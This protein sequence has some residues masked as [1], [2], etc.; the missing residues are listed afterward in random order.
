MAMETTSRY[1][2][3]L[4]AV[5]KPFKKLS[6]I[7]FL[8]PDNSIAFSLDNNYKRGYRTKY[9]TRAFIQSGTL[10]VSL[11]NGERRKATITLSNLDRAFDYAVNKI[12]FGQKI[13]LSMGLVLPDGTDFYL[14]QGVFYIKDPRNTFQPDVKQAT[15]P[16]VDKWNYLN[17]TLFGNLENSYQVDR[18]TNIFE[19]MAS[20]LKLSKYDY[21]NNADILAQ[22]DNVTPVFTNYYNDKIYS[23][24]NGDGSTTENIAMTAVPYTLTESGNSNFSKVILGLN[25]MLAGIIGY[26]QTGA[27]RV[28]PS[29]DDIDDR[30][31][32]IYWAFTPENSVLLGLT[33]NIKNS[34]VKNDII[35]V[36]E[37][38]TG[39]EV[40]G[41]AT[42]YD[43]ASDTNVNLI[44]KKTLRIENGNYW[45]SEQCVALAEWQLKR[46]TVLQKSVSI[47]STQLFHL[48]ENGLVSVKRTD[49]EGSP[50]ERHIVQSFS[51]PIG[52][53]GNMTINAT[54]VN[55][56]PQI[57]VTS[58]SEV[59]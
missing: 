24:A 26:D 58:S 59:S 35:V 48:V 56:F 43:P 22:I 29:Q 10:N 52:E 41:R 20:I 49:K 25:D 9:D 16:L 34:D 53:T 12:W 33:E 37:G 38:L 1:I 14:P 27:L 28:E 5:S 4:N 32:P 19:A 54:S 57:T 2:Q 8:Q 45:N 31:K 7:E 11:Q 55:D 36:G 30:E 13:R 6:K 42:N 46:K 50:V 3:Y 17:G 40:Y 44:G 39:L 18:N 47:E 51:L 21:S 23:V 15:F